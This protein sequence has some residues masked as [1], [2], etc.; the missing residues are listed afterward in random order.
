MNF[1]TGSLS[2][3]SR[4]LTFVTDSVRFVLPDHWRIPLEAHVDRQV[5]LGIRPEHI[6]PRIRALPG[7]KNDDVIS[8][9]IEST[10]ALGEEQIVHISLGPQQ[11]A[12]KADSHYRLSA[13]ERIDLQLHIGKA[14]IF[15][16][17]NGKN[18][19]LT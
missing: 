4:P 13:G 11:L 5:T 17:G 18:L 10:E 9:I 15:D 7:E 1:L 8:G 14:H 19:I 16:A 3:D 2:I 12:C 6:R